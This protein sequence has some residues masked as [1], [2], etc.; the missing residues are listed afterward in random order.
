[1]NKKKTFKKQKGSSKDTYSKKG[2]FAHPYNPGD[3][4]TLTGLKECIMEAF[5]EGDHDTLQGAIAI[6]LDK[7]EYKEILEKTGLSKKS[8]EKM[9]MPHPPPKYEFVDKILKFL[10]S[11]TQAH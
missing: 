1:M 8:L 4:V 11:K 5:S 3:D 6:L 7:C 2:I 10:S 9:L